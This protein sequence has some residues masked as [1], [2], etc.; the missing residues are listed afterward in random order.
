MICGGVW[1]QEEVRAENQPG[2]ARCADY[3]TDHYPT[4]SHG[5]D[6]LGQAVD[7]GQ[8]TGQMA[9]VR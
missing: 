3:D 6:L 5:E 9:N 7:R 8:G 1:A 2:C 4:L